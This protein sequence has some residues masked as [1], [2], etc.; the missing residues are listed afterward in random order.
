[1][2]ALDRTLQPTRRVL[3]DVDPVQPLDTTHPLLDGLQGFW[4]PLPRL[5]GGSR[6]YDLSAYNRKG[7]LEDTTGWATDSRWPFPAL[8]FDGSNDRVD[9]GPP[10]V[11]DYPSTIAGLVIPNTI[12]NG[13]IIGLRDPGGTFDGVSMTVRGTGEIRYFVRGNGITSKIFGGQY[14]AGDRVFAVGV[15]YSNTD[16]RLF[17]PTQVGSSSTDHSNPNIG[18]AYIGRH[19]TNNTWFAPLDGRVGF[20]AT[21]NRALSPNEVSVLNSQARRGFPDLLNRR[22]DVGLLGGGGG[23]IVSGVSAEMLVDHQIKNSITAK[24]QIGS[25]VNLADV[26]G[27]RVEVLQEA[28]DEVQ[29]IESLAYALAVSKS[30]SENLG[31]FDGVDSAARIQE[32]ISD[33]A[34]FEEKVTQTLAAFVST[35]ETFTLVDDI[36]ST[37]G[38]LTVDLPGGRTL[39]VDPGS[40]TYSI[41]SD[42]RII[43]PSS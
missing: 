32:Q 38:T 29:I 35:S 14:T 12:H 33:N 27:Q 39:T 8:T 34:A 9:I 28:Q 43:K 30:Q 40:R 42:S 36:R 10:R 18:N 2:D 1:M 15:S 3:G 23:V 17:A 21:W 22:S 31:L 37:K 13:T 6:L 4:L 41:S 16:H 19:R 11:T 5:T 20:A 7:V 26:I 24:S 25:V